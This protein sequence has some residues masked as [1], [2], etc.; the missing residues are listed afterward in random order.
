[1]KK[2]LLV[3]IIIFCSLLSIIVPITSLGQNVVTTLIHSPQSPLVCFR[4]LVHTGS[5]SDPAGKEG[6]CE[7][8]ARTIARGGTQSLTRDQII[9]KLYP[10]AATIDVNTDKEVTVF[11]GEVRKDWLDA[12]YEIFA[13]L[14]LKP[15]F[16]SSDFGREK[17][18]LINYL[19]NTLRGADDEELGKEVLNDFIY[20]NHP[21]GHCN[22]GTVSGLK[23]ITLDDVKNFYKKMFTRDNIK[24]GLAGSYTNEFLNRVKANFAAL[25]AGK[26][27]EIQLSEPEKIYDIEVTIV[28]KPCQGTAIS[29]GFPIDITRAGKDYYALLVANS[30]FGEH[31]TMG[32][33]LMQHMRIFRG[34][35]YG[36]YSYIENFIQDRGSRLPMPNIPR[37]QQFFSIWIRPVTHD[38]RHFALRQAIRELELLVKDGLTEEEFEVSRQ[39]VLNNSKLWTQTLSRRLGYKM[40]SEFYGIDYFVDKVEDEISRLTVNDVNAAIKKYLQYKNIKVAIV[41]DNAESLKE[42]LITDKVSPIHYPKKEVPED[43]LAED[44]II[45]KHPLNIKKEKLQIILAKSLFE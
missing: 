20:H 44:K 7:L 24:V 25:P 40:D 37:R 5:I 13:G 36:D 43:I 32:G 31:R 15:R 12:F 34:L 38:N 1:M 41:T 23:S 26:I 10:M 29:L 3:S 18:G 28:N 45:E 33:R 11:I 8:T 4:I 19:R 6:L 2:F 42:D 21:Y 30:Y 16:D 27:A 14:L 39:Y 17:N 9:Q 35:N 22:K